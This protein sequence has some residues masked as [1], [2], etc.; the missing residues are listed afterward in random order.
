MAGK[1]MVTEEQLIKMA[2]KQDLTPEEAARLVEIEKT[3]PVP[4]QPLPEG[5]VNP[6]RG[7]PRHLCLDKRGA[8]Q[9]TWFQL[10]LHKRDKNT[11]AVQYFAC[12]KNK[13]TVPVGKWVDV[14]PAI[15]DVLN[16]AVEQQ[17]ENVPADD[18]LGTNKMEVRLV[19][20]NPRFSYQLY[21]SGR[22]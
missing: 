15:I 1:P 16:M 21:A 13:Y 22:V 17:V 11:P 20:E 3:T 7:D 4:G 18:E 9:P 19:G 8:F 5:F 14:P 6:P 12:A 2:Q 10:R